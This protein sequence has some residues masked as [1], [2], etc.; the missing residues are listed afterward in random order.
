MANG[1][2]KHNTEDA[3]AFS[4]IFDFEDPLLGEKYT[5]RKEPI[6][7]TSETRKGKQIDTATP[8]QKNRGWL[9]SWEKGRKRVATSPI[10]FHADEILPMASGLMNSADALEEPF[11]DSDGQLF[12]GKGAQ[13]KGPMYGLPLG[14]RMQSLLGDV[15]RGDDIVDCYVRGLETPT[16]RKTYALQQPPSR[17]YG[18]GGPTRD[19]RDSDMRAQQSASDLKQE[20]R[21]TKDKDE[22]ISILKGQNKGLSNALSGL[23]PSS[24]SPSSNPRRKVSMT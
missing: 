16:R 13:R 23:E 15:K 10:S 24:S 14:V 22:L 9:S 1:N 2:G 12:G 8:N 21:A 6:V 5:K 3:V 18:L 19:Q 17:S 20:Q 11:R 7:G 4:N